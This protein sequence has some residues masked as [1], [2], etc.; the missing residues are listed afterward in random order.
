MN[1]NEQGFVSELAQRLQAPTYIPKQVPGREPEEGVF[2]LPPGWKIGEP[3][4]PPDVAPIMIHT[5]TG[6]RDY[7]AANVD[8]LPKP[9][10]MIHVLSPREVHLIEA[11]EGEEVRFRRTTYVKAAAEVPEYPFGRFLDAEEFM[12]RAMTLFVDTPERKR[13]LEFMASIRDSTVVET[14]DDGVRQEVKIAKGITRLDNAPVPN[15]VNLQPYRTFPEVDQPGSPFV[16]RLRSGDEDSKPAAALFDCDGGKWRIEAIQ[17]IAS[18]LR[19]EVPDVKVVAWS[20]A[21]WL[22]REVPDVKV[23]A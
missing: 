18:W 23:V 4:A 12:I 7:L 19:R 3:P 2:V 20:I 21:S 5:L 10:Q 6:I 11:F 22:R 1:T 9:E 15:P 14:G 13:L 17:S 16:L 8:D